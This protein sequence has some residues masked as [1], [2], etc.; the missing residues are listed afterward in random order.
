MLKLNL[1][2]FVLAGLIAAVPFFAMVQPAQARHHH[3]SWQAATVYPSQFPKHDNQ[4]HSVEFSG[5]VLRPRGSEKLRIMADDS[6][7]YTLQATFPLNGW[8]AGRRI[9]VSAV[10]HNRDVHVSHIWAE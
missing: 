2:P 3:Q 1:K 9:H 5:T 8:T 10:S 7:K 4:W 6:E